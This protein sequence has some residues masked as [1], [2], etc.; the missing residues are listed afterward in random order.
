[1][2]AEEKG[3]MDSQVFLTAL[4]NSGVAQLID[5]SRYYSIGF[6]SVHILA[7]TLAL[8]VVVL[9]NIR[10]NGVGLASLGLREFVVSIRRWYHGA[11]LVSVVAGVLI[12]LPRAVAYANNTVFINKVLL[13]LVAIVAQWLLLE[14]IARS[15]DNERPGPAIRLAFAAALLLWFGVGAYGRAIGFV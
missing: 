5:S 1:L 15:A 9:F 11:V 8:A 6:Q 4:Q 10:L 2:I 3:E 12:F 13:L 7:F 14:R